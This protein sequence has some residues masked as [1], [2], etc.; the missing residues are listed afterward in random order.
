M[1]YDISMTFS[2]KLS[3]S[4]ISAKGI[5]RLGICIAVFKVMTFC[6]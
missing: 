4:A 6:K 2:E 3:L 1:V 5:D